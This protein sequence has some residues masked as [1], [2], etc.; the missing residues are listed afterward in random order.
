MWWGLVLGLLSL[1]VVSP[2][3]ASYMVVTGKH[4]YHVDAQLELQR[5]LGRLVTVNESGDH[6]ATVHVRDGYKDAQAGSRSAPTRGPSTQVRLED[7]TVRV[8]VTNRAGQLQ[9]GFYVDQNQFMSQA[10]EYRLSRARRLTDSPSSR[11]T[12]PRVDFA[13]GSVNVW[14]S[15]AN[16]GRFARRSLGIQLVCEP[17]RSIPTDAELLPRPSPMHGRRCA[18]R[19]STSCTGRIKDTNGTPQPKTGS[20]ARES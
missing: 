4:T 9:T 2:V 5:R 3:L 17:A 13:F 19:S 16:R 12:T 6:S 7:P 11:P 14:G 15:G 18:S 10:D 1:V 8:D 20:G